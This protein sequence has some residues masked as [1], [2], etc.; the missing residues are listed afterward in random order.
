MPGKSPDFNEHGDE[1][2][3]EMLGLD[4]DTV[5]DLKVKGVV[6]WTAPTTV[7]VRR[8]R[9]KTTG[10]VLIPGV[11]CWRDAGR[12]ADQ[13][14]VGEAREQLRQH[15][16]RLA[17]GEAGAEAE[18]LGEAERDLRRIGVA[19]HV[20]LVTALPGVL[21]AVGRRVEEAARSRPA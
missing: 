21:V 8:Q 7:G 1:I 18:V 12:V 10:I 14:V 4:W 13:L 3:T 2:L 11:M 19:P 15:D 20:E 5:I 16:A 17:A 6:A 9:R